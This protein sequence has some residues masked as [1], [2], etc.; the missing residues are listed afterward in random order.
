MFCAL[1]VSSGAL[2]PCGFAF[3]AAAGKLCARSRLWKPG[4]HQSADLWLVL[5]TFELTACL[6]E[7]KPGLRQNIDFR[8]R[9]ATFVIATCY[10]DLKPGVQI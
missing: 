8:L 3:F 1:G 7:L 4:V 9:L 5:A 10:M 2:V 6:A